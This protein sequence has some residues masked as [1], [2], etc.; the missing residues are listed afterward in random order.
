MGEIALLLW[1]L[2]GHQGLLVVFAFLPGA[3][4]RRK[5]FCVF[6]SVT[7]STFP[8]HVKCVWSSEADSPAEAESCQIIFGVLVEGCP[9]KSDVGPPGAAC[10]GEVE[11]SI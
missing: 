3:A 7:Q 2:P 5:L 4:P 6:S 10:A 9:S 11:G 8:G 1:D